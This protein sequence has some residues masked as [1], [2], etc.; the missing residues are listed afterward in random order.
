MALS[1]AGCSSTSSSISIYTNS[2]QAPAADSAGGRGEGVRE[3]E[4]ELFRSCISNIF[5]AYEEF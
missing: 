5:N 1:G 3:E 4:L 2:Y